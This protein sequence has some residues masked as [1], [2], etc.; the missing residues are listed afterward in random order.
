[1]SFTGFCIPQPGITLDS[2]LIPAQNPEVLPPESPE[3]SLLLRIVFYT[4]FVRNH[5]LCQESGSSY[6]FNVVFWA[7]EDAKVT[8]FRV[9]LARN[10]TLNRPKVS[11]SDKTAIIA[12]IEQK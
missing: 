4:T 10:T 5:H 7:E 9:I 3:S 6:W 8:E 1:M 11:K 12:Q 2:S